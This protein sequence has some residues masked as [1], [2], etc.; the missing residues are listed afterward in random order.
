ME[1]SAFIQS[2]NIYWVPIILTD[3]MLE[4]RKNVTSKLKKKSQRED[5]TYYCQML[6][7]RFQYY[8][9]C[10]EMDSRKLKG[11]G[12]SVEKLLNFKLCLLL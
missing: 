5:D 8:G 11:K 7:A 9:I 4:M 6:V 2:A 12:Q 1:K 10:F 3:S